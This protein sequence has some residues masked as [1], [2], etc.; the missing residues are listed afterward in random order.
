[1]GLKLPDLQTSRFYG[2]YE[3][4]RRKS[5]AGMTLSI[6]P[7]RTFLMKL[8]SRDMATGTW[9]NTGDTLTL[10]T[11]PLTEQQRTQVASGEVNW[12]SFQHEGILLIKDRLIDMKNGSWQLRRLK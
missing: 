8:N 2:D 7:D 12:V 9:D 1:M 11:R 10:T 4:G 6:N 3:A 5:N